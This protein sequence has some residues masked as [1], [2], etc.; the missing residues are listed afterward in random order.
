M[1]D[2]ADRLSRAAELACNA[3][4]GAFAFVPGP[5][6]RYLSGLDFHLMER[7]TLMFV[8]A[9]NEVLAIMP[10][11]ERVKWSGAFPDA[12]TF[13]WT[14]SDGFGRAFASC[15]AC[16]SGQ[17]G[18]EGRR[19]R[20]FEFA[21]LAGALPADAVQDAEAT[22]AELRICKSDAQVAALGR[23]I[24]ISETALSAFLS[25]ARCGDSE[26][27]LVA[28][29]KRAMLD[30]GAEGFSFDPIVLSGPNTAKPHGTP[31]DRTIAPG[32]PLLV[33]FGASFEGMNADITRTVFCQC[34]SD[35]AQD[36]YRT[37]LAAN[38]RGR[39]VAKA[40][41]SCDFVDRAT[42]EVLASSI[43]ADLI[44]HK[45]GHGLGLEVHEAPQVMVGDMTVLRAGMVVT[46]EPGLYRPGDIG[47]RIEDDVL[48]TESGSECLTR[49]PRQMRFFRLN[50]S[51]KTPRLS[52]RG[53]QRTCGPS[54]SR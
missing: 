26:A 54:R 45:T 40:G 31:G 19:M 42:T 8:T 23:A 44:V 36:M 39:E 3:G 52:R 10:E 51:R 7:P 47:I 32:E 33:D 9:R 30:K 25:G 4:F 24:E 41:A 21:A 29:L 37:V 17:V 34:A 49:F 28:R 5:N 53:R 1:D 38:L 20:M 35:E 22:L 43:H 46:I 27:A 16:L 12:T 50:R 2:H 48:I 15:A 14:D 6:F 11:L 13:Y 18:V